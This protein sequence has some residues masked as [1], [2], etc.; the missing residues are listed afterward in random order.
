MFQNNQCKP[1]ISNIKI[2]GHNW[3]SSSIQA[4]KIHIIQAKFMGKEN[5]NRKKKE[6]RNL[7]NHKQEFYFSNAY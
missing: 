6:E 5:Q 3:N 7:N 4:T 2:H 1:L